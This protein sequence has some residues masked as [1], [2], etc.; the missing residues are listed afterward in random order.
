MCKTGHKQRKTRLP[1]KPCFSLICAGG[2]KIRSRVTKL[3]VR[4]PL[5]YELQKSKYSRPRL[6]RFFRFATETCLL[7]SI[8]HEKPAGAFLHPH[9][10]TKKEPF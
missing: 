3:F 6:D 1:K 2:E 8:L 4:S 10:I 9:T 5:R 7:L